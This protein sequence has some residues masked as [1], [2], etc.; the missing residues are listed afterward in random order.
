M[1][2]QSA[3]NGPHSVQGL[4]AFGVRAE[5]FRGRRFADLAVVTKLSRRSVLAMRCSLSLVQLR[6]DSWVEG[7]TPTHSRQLIGL[8]N[9]LLVGTTNRHGGADP[10]GLY[11]SL[12]GS[13]VNH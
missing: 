2:S 1:I 7:S 12:Y 13:L 9:G 5:Y 6:K 8:L 4:E 3:R 10:H 11:A